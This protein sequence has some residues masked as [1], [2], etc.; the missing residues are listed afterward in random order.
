MFLWKVSKKE[1]LEFAATKHNLWN[2][3]HFLHLQVP[4]QG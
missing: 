3:S 4:D 1:L 2:L